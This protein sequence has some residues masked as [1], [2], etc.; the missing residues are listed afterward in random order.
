MENGTANP[1]VAVEELS[2]KPE[3]AVKETKDDDVLSSD[4]SLSSEFDDI[5]EY[6][7]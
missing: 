1:K 7:E 5:D 4:S 6:T 3:M 2:K